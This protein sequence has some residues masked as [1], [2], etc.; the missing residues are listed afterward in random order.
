MRKEKSYKEAVTPLSRGRELDDEKSLGVATGLKVGV[1][2]CF[3]LILLV[4]MIY[5]TF[6]P[7]VKMI[8]SFV[9]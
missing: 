9:A 8:T 7:M 2:A 1:I 4:L 3:L 6:W 5:F